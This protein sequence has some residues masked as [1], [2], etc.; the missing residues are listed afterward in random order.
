MMID[1]NRAEVLKSKVLPHFIKTVFFK[2][3]FILVLTEEAIEVFN[4]QILFTK[5]NSNKSF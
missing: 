4:I 3:E 2:F 1:C 5:M